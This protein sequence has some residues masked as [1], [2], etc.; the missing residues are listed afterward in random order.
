M[1]VEGTLLETQAA[2]VAAESTLAATPGISPLHTQQQPAHSP[3][4]SPGAAGI[5]ADATAATSADRERDMGLQQQVATITAL[6]LENAALREEMDR[7]SKRMKQID[8]HRIDIPPTVTQA[9]SQ[10]LLAPQRRPSPAVVVP[11]DPPH[12]SIHWSE[13]QALAAWQ[14]S[15]ALDMP[16]PLIEHAERFDAE[17]YLRMPPSAATVNATTSAAFSVQRDVTSLLD[18]LKPSKRSESRRA[19]VLSFLK[20]LVRKSLG[21]QVYPLGAFAL[22]TYVGPDEPMDV[23]AFFSR[24]HEHTWLHR[25][26]SSA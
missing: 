23:S 21:A 5:G 16:L 7:L 9:Q 3:S 26:V 4:H 22:K 25:I 14:S 8:Q 12:H 18:Y 24:A 17:P 15:Q 10:S 19:N 6:Q 20:L 13:E 2:A 1:P 11:V